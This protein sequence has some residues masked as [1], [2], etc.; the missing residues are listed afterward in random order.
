MGRE[1]VRGIFLPQ[2][3]KVL[4]LVDGQIE[5]VNKKFGAGSLKVFIQ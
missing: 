4:E 1:E 5:Q 3:Y 2:F